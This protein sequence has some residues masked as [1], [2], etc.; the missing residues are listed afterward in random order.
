VLIPVKTRVAE[1]PGET[2]IGYCSLLHIE[3]VM[4]YDGPG[5]WLSIVRYSN[6]F[7]LHALNTTDT[8]RDKIRQAEQV[9]HHYG[10]RRCQGPLHTGMSLQDIRF[11]NCDCVL[12]DMFR[13][14]LRFNGE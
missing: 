8:L 14:I 13:S 9:R 2:T 1:T 6:G 5:A 7:E 3:E 4:N 10:K 11:P 12:L